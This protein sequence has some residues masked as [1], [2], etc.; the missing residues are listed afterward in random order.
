MPQLSCAL[1]KEGP[2]YE[3]IGASP[4]REGCDCT[5]DNRGCHHGTVPSPRDKRCWFVCCRNETG[6]IQTVARLPFG[7]GGALETEPAPVIPFD[8]RLEPRG[9][10]RAA[11][12][13]VLHLFRM[14]FNSAKCDKTTAM[15]LA[16]EPGLV[17]ARKKCC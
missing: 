7:Q 11:A 13:F 5:I 9:S 16:R 6:K 14:S 15:S 1:C 10:K 4:L 12:C 8:P 17:A 2:T 3:K